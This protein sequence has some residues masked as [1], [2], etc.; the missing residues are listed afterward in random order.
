MARKRRGEGQTALVTGASA[1]IGVDLAE[2]FARDGYNLVLAARSEA[3]LKE[4]AERLSLKY[5]IAATPIALDLTEHGAGRKLADAIAAKGLSVD[6]LVNNAG[7]GIAGGFDGSSEADQLGMIDLNVRA[8]VELTHIYWPAMLKN[9]RGGV[10]NVAST[11]AFQPG[12]LMA[13]Y[14]ASKA[15][16]L[17][18]SEALWKEAE[19]S[20]V[21]VS[22]LCPGPTSSKFR[23]RA[24]TGRT[25]LS[26]MGTPMPS[27]TVARMGYRA[28]QN[29][30]RVLVTG[31]RNRLIA[32]LARF[33]PRKTLLATVYNIQSPAAPEA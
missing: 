27:M 2:C 16:V 18:F 26:R 8:L 20:A 15:F 24:G 13:V 11:A 3:A 22:C 14:Y 29:N 12:P 33:L 5:A 19:G 31:M 28:F 10:L 7:Y 9:N 23:E 17:S 6:V 4:V 21:H 1:G 25:R 32:G 30:R